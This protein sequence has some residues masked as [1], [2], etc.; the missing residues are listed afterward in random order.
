MAGG[1]AARAGL[2]RGASPALA[3]VLREDFVAAYEREW[4]V[5]V[6]CFPMIS[7]RAL[8]ICDFRCVT[9]R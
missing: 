1:R 7:T 9:A 5:V 8:P 2:L 3:T 4:P 6:Q